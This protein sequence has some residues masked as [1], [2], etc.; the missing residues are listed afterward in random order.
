MDSV[1][2]KRL[3]FVLIL[4]LVLL[5]TSCVAFFTASATDGDVSSVSSDISGVSSVVS[6]DIDDASQTESSQSSSP[7]SSESS[8]VSQ[9][10]SSQTASKPS[11]NTSVAAKVSPTDTSSATSQI[12]YPDLRQPGETVSNY[13]GSYTGTSS[14]STQEDETPTKTPATAKKYRVVAIVGIIVFGL[15]SL[16]AAGML[17][18]F[19]LKVRKSKK[20]HP[21]LYP[22]KEKT[23]KKPKH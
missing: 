7:A 9:S 23:D 21:E 5:C 1:Y 4:S 22:V 6:S 16:G 15:L 8:A 14:N 17:I 20:E 13:N 19:N 10:P 12:S 2:T 11:G 3:I 18:Y